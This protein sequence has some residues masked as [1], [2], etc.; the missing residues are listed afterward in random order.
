V[1]EPVGLEDR[2][3]EVLRLMEEQGASVL[4]MTGTC[5]IGKSTLGMRV[6]QELARRL[7][8]PFWAVNLCHE[9]PAP[10]LAQQVSQMLG[11]SSPGAAESRGVLL[12]DNVDAALTGGGF[13]AGGPGLWSTA[14]VE[15][16]RP[17]RLLIVTATAR[18]GSSRAQSWEVSPLGL[19]A[20]PGGEL[21][22]LISDAGA[23]FLRAA[24]QA[25]AEWSTDERAG[26]P[27]GCHPM[28]SGDG[29]SPGADRAGRAFGEYPTRG[30]GGCLASSTRNAP[31]RSVAG[32]VE[33]PPRRAPCLLA[34]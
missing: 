32:Y 31:M 10:W 29:N 13:L 8:E 21:S 5:G 4:Y 25:G 7:S 6:G 18:T 28:P 26:V 15:G 23:L 22:V 9:P 30:P 17:P 1:I 11:K 34:G 16:A 3:A 27:A 12:L 19:P 14:V 2:A 20:S 33:H 24:G